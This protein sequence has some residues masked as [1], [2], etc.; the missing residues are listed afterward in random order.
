M[1]DSNTAQEAQSQQYE[2]RYDAFKNISPKLIYPMAVKVLPADQSFTKWKWT[3]NVV[4]LVLRLVANQAM[5]NVSLR[6]GSACRLI[7]FIRLYR[8]LEDPKN[9]SYIERLFDFIISIA[10]ALTNRFKRRPKS[11]DI[12][13]DVK[14]NQ[15]PDQ[16]QARVE[17]M[18]DDIQQQSKT[19]DPVKHLSFED[20]R[21]LFQIIYLPD[22]SNHFLEDRS[23]AAQRVAGANPLVI[24]QV[25][26]LPEYFKVTEEHYTKVMGKDD[27]L[28]AALDEGR[29][30][31][32]DYKILDEIDP[33]TVEVGVNGSIKE[34][35]EKFGYA[36]LALFAIASGDCPGRL[37]TP[38]A[39]QCSQDAGSLIF[40]PPSIAA[41]DEERWAWRMAKTVVQVADGNYHEL[42]SHLGRTH[43][44]IEP[45]A[46]GTYR[47]LAKHKLGK[48]L[49]P[50]FEGTFF[51]NNA[52]AGSLI[53]KG[54]VVESILSGT[55]LSSVTLSV[56]AAKG[57]PFA[58][59]DSMLP[60]TF[61]ARGVDDPQKLP[62]YPY[63]DDALLIW[64]AIHKW[65]KSYLEVY[66]SSD[67][68]VLSDAV[69]QAWLAELVAEDGG[70]MTEIG[71][72][73][74]EDRRPKIRT[75]DYLIDATTLIIFT[76]SVQHAA[77]N[78][79]QASLMSFAPNM[80]LAGFNAAPTTLK[81]SEADYFSMLPSLSLAEQQMNF[82]YTLG[83]VYYTQIGQYKA[84]EVE[85]EEMN[86]HDY[87]GD[88][89]ISHHLEIFQ[90]KLKEIELTIQQRNETRPTFYDILL[91]SK[92][93]QSTNI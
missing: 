68:E 61:A 79:T 48:L 70:Q 66:Y 74:P 60:K 29:I 33:G 41:V 73:I 89:R 42:I 7:T 86:Q 40:T 56:K 14:Q 35:I 37:L 27:S 18:V 88:S 34:T 25:S 3:K 26:E 69:L 92:I 1:T 53:A 12:E 71:E 45:I 32:A 30:Y 80:P 91:P 15:K 84:N 5:Q 82:G 13:Q 87:F 21:N 81:V 51:I 19:K 75:L 62:D 65:V 6:K 17:A 2:Y 44:W 54:G 36:P 20:Y 83:S 11:Q 52:A 59:N 72:V 67:D 47:R 85:L 55:L 22:I 57:Y 46:L 77:V 9:S 24:M 64:D 90:N 49:L 78:F 39:I 63:R 31:L 38:V 16:V 8:I 76:C 93:P 50:H 23:F 4:S 28:Q 58:F 43:L 10:R